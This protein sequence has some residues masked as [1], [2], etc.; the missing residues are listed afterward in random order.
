M[1]ALTVTERGGLWSLR[2][3]GAVFPI[4]EGSPQEVIEYIKR[5]FTGRG[6]VEMHREDGGVDHVK[7]SALTAA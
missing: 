3:R 5:N 6:I 4:L 7:I 2:P 1:N